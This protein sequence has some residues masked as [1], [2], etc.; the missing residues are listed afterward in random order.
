MVLLRETWRELVDARELYR[1]VRQHAEKHREL[2]CHARRAAAPLSFA[3]REAQLIHTVR[4]ECVAG[5]VAVCAA[6]VDLREVGEDE[7]VEPVRAADVALQAS[8]EAVIV[9]AGGGAR[10]LAPGS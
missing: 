2:S 6:R 9:E 7:S 3:F 4:R 1:S 10:G 5:P 8:E